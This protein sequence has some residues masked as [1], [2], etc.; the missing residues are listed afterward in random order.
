LPSIQ[1]RVA[2]SKYGLYRLSD[3]SQRREAD[4]KVVDPRLLLLQ[5]GWSRFPVALVPS[6]VQDRSHIPLLAAPDFPSILRR[7][8][9]GPRRKTWNIQIL[10]RLV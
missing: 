9:S 5:G 1:Q 4:V 6:T 2:G 8:G 7:R 10:Y 3:G